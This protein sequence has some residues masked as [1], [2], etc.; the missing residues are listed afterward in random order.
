MKRGEYFADQQHQIIEALSGG[1]AVY[2]EARQCFEF[3]SHASKVMELFGYTISEFDRIVEEDALNIIVEEDHS[4]LKKRIAESMRRRESFN[5]HVRYQHKD[6]HLYWV[7]IDGW[8]SD[9]YYLLFTGLSAK[10][11]LFQ[12]VVSE[13]GDDIYVINKENYHVLYANELKENRLDP[14]DFIGKRC[15]KA[16]HGKNEPCDFCNLKSQSVDSN[17]YELN[18]HYYYTHFHEMDWNGIPAYVKYVR[19]ISDEVNQQMEKE[20]LEEYFQTVL[21]YLPGGVAVVHHK[22]GGSLTPDFLSEGFAK[23]VDMDH[24]TAWKMYCE[25]ALFGVHPDDREYVRRNL[26]YCILNGEERY[27]MQYRLRKGKQGYLWVKAMFSVIQ[28]DGGDTRVYVHYHDITEEKRQQEELR[29]QYK[30]QILQHYL[31]SGPNSLILGHCNITKNRIIEIVDHTHS[32]LLDNFGDVREDFFLGI[33]SLVVDEKEREQFYARYLNEPSMAAYSRG[34]T[35][36]LLSCFIKLPKEEVGRYVQ[37]KVN[38]VETPDTGDITGILTITDISEQM[39]NDKILEQLSLVNYD[40]IVDVDL[41]RDKYSLVSGKLVDQQKHKLSQMLG[42][43]M[44]KVVPRERN[45]VKRMLDKDYL[46]HRLNKEGMYSFSYSIIDENEEIRTKSVSV[47][48]IDLRLG[49]VCL[50]RM[51][52]SDSLREQRGFL[53]MIAYTFELVCFVDTT[54]KVLSMHTRDTVL[55]NLPPFILNNYDVEID[56]FV[57]KFSAGD[58]FDQSEQFRLDTMLRRLK[59]SPNGY[60]FVFSYRKGKELRYKQVNVLW[61]DV[62]HKM[63]GLVRADVTDAL[64]EERKRKIE[65]EKAL[66]LAKKA[67]RVKSDFLSSMSHDIRTPMNAIMGMTSL[68]IANLENKDKVAEYLHKISISSSH[69]L[70]LINDILDMSQI[71]QSKIHLNFTQLSMLVLIADIESMMISQA[72]DRRLSFSIHKSDLQHDEFIG[73]GLRIKQILI[74]LLSNA[75][76]FTPEGGRVDFYVEEIPS[77]KGKLRYRFKVADNGI[78]MNE[79]FL[80]HLFEPFTRNKSVSK[81]EGTGLGLSIT[82]GLV[83]LMEGDIH[84]ESKLHCGTVFSVELECDVLKEGMSRRSQH[85]QM[86]QLQKKDLEGLHFLVVEDNAIN[87]EIICELLAMRGATSLVKENGL[88]ALQEFENAPVGSYDAI[89]MDIQMPVMNGFE[90]A[91]AIRESAHPD[92][93]SILIIAMTANAFVEDVQMAL[94]SGMDGHVAK[95][96]DMEILCKTLFQLMK[97]RGK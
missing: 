62:G 94:R 85:Q 96:V 87:S 52:I 44:E 57:H 5:M 76:K 26:D 28:S 91:K 95:P 35:E 30:E 47:S 84:V 27:G 79:E 46:L 55:K 61:G 14:N 92:A 12:N 70:S 19:D 50:A 66:D 10:M 39:I 68:A 38:L 7:Q 59:E 73:D 97:E 3:C 89:F 42:L 54:S 37:F 24:D 58:E 20:R 17:I 23:M 53:N 83:D 63:I 41:L 48:A 49:R 80:T 74:N 15:Y 82:K 78:G 40:L 13:T 93:K 36:I 9:S 81:V 65:L 88:L 67:N 77:L 33:G 16:F 43:L 45:L 4:R 29:L 31:G 34:E 11:R 69:L 72:K 22:V 18:G 1:L 75:F 90:A 2:R 71:E 8:Y 51:D 32:D 21:K 6:G 60:D 64:A 56:K 86:D 25:D